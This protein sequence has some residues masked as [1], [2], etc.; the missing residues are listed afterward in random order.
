M[1]RPSRIIKNYRES[2]A[3]NGMINIAAVLD[4]HTLATKSGD[5]M[6]TLGVF[7]L[8]DE[9]QEPSQVDQV[10]RH[11][12]S[13]A[14][15]LGE[16]VRVHQFLIKRD[17]AT[18]PFRRYD[19]PVVRRTIENRMAHFQANSDHIYS[20]EVYFVVVYEERRSA[21]ASRATGFLR[22]PSK[23]RE[24]FSTHQSSGA[25]AQHLERAREILSSKLV[26]FVAQL[27]DALRV[28]ML[29][30]DRA[31]RFLRR[32]VN[33]APH[34]ADVGLKYD[35]F[36]DFQMCGSALECHR[37]H[38]RL[39]D[40]FVSVL[41]LKEPPGRTF[42]HVL[43]GLQQIPCNLVIA[44]EWKPESNLKMLRQ[45]HSRRRH[46]HNSKASMMNYLSSSAQN[47]PKDMLIDDAAV[48][49]VGDLGTCLE[50]LEVRGRSF[51]QFSMTLVLFD[52]DRTRLKH[53]VAGCFRV[54]STQDAQLIEERYNLLNAWLAVIPGNS[55]YNLRRLWVLDN[56][57]A[58]LSFLFTP[59]AGEIQ[60][61]HLGG[62]EYLAVLET[63]HGTPYFLN[64]HVGDVA[65]TIILGGTGSG[66]SFLVN[67]L[68]THAQK[69]EPLTYL[70]DLGGGYENLTH[71]FGGTY[72]PVGVDKRGFTINPFTLPPT[73]ENLHFLFSFL[74]V[75]IEPGVGALTP[76]EERDLY[77][78]IENVY[79]IDA[80]QRR[81]F[82]LSNMLSR[83]LRAPLQKWV[84]GGPYASL[85]D[86][87]QDNL[88]FAR[89]QTFDFEGMDKIPQIL[90]P[91]L[92]Y[93]LHR[94]TT[95]IYDAGQTTALKFFVID[96][97]W[98]FLRHPTI[99]QY[100]LEALKTWRKKNAAMILATQSSDDLVRSEILSAVVESCPTKMFL[101]NPDIDQKAYRELFHLNETEA[102]LIPRLIPKRQILIK[103]PDTA[104]VVNLNVGPKDYW[105]YTSNPYDRER[106]REAFERYGFEQGLEIL[107][108]SP[109]S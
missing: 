17:N 72:L 100:I 84:E 91:L 97:A 79:V 3:L 36:I 78:Q 109:S 27:P 47:Q 65:H 32:L 57:Y 55:A 2:G 64:L 21:T 83:R 12:E 104:K 50:E 106:R 62:A 59:H 56:N 38:L 73:K 26:H 5:V 46:F 49:Q 70:F 85:F 71:L 48:A 45:I 44:S 88:T 20:L 42:A 13:A 10:A 107:S 1:I 61:A 98:R 89:F 37:D 31:F 34:K 99:R 108:R 7:G 15:T 90:E 41:T 93:I 67:Y 29:D 52:E 75:L 82:T 24:W 103:R 4:E 92:F 87:A 11:F 94:A 28:E 95:A 6:M 18:I 96:E 33:Y 23:W 69:Y 16:N 35:D 60:N 30:K 77:E 40:F 68:L 63:N 86:N 19:N 80:D 105:L 14:R 76:E 22:D 102:A 43:K 54:F 66:K 58:D 51:G 74:R 9:C 53:A 39:D 81:L 25:V 101:A 8:D